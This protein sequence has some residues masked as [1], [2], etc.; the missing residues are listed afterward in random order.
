MQDYH[1]MPIEQ[2]IRELRTDPKNGL[3]EEEAKKRLRR[4]GHNELTLA[5]TVASE[6]R[7]KRGR[8]VVDSVKSFFRSARDRVKQYA[9]EVS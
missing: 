7:V 5:R 2:V 4:E 3:T 6:K 8:I 9:G 1:S